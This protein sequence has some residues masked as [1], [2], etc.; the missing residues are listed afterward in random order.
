MFWPSLCLSFT[1]NTCS[2]RTWK[3][4]SRGPRTSLFSRAFVREALRH[5]L[6]VIVLSCVTLTSERPSS[7]RACV[8]SE[9]QTNAKGLRADHG[10][11][12]DP[13]S[14]ASCGDRTRTGGA[15]ELRAQDRAARGRAAGDHTRHSWLSRP[16]LVADVTDAGLDRDGSK[17]PTRN[18]QAGT[19]TV[20]GEPKWRRTCR[21]FQ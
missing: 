5:L 11:G 20:R 18:L 21:H 19:Q 4:D 1:E 17:E 8:G 3:K 9:S 2:R 10:D 6:H 7:T 13:R 15:N 12:R 16:L 14:G